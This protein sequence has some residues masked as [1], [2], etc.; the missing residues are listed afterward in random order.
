MFGAQRLVMGAVL[1]AGPAPVVQQQSHPL[2]SCWMC[3][4]RVR[5]APGRVAH[6]R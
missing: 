2:E 6:L 3:Q 4:A 5:S 1:W